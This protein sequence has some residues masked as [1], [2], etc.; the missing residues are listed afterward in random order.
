MIQRSPKPHL[1]PRIHMPHLSIFVLSMHQAFLSCLSISLYLPRRNLS[2]L[3]C[4]GHQMCYL[5]ASRIRRLV[6]RNCQFLGHVYK[7]HTYLFLTNL[8]EINIII[9]PKFLTLI[10]H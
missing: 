8:S 10:I 7:I 3:F 2:F 4:Q 9:D 5:S 1:L 6:A